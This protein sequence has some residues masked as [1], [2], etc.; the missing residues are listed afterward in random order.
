VTTEQIVRDDEHL[1]RFDAAKGFDLT[2][3]FFASSLHYDTLWLAGLSKPFV[4][5]LGPIDHQRGWA[6]HE[7][8]LRFFKN[9]EN[10]GV[11]EVKVIKTRNA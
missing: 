10:D 3:P 5:F 4:E 7:K 11:L 9:E 6:N 8:A 2:E 1:R